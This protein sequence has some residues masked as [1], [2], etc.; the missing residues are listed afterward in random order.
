MPSIGSC[1]SVSAAAAEG[2]F[3][4]DVMFMAAV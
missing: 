3:K 2:V 1:H 4:A